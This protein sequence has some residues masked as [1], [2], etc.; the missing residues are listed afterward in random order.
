MSAVNRPRRD[1]L[2][3]GGAL[4]VSFAAPG[5]VTTEGAREAA[6]PVAGSA[7]P[8]TI[9]PHQLDSWLRIA[10]DGSVTASVGK[11]EA[12]MGIGTAF[13]QVVAEELDVPIE[14]VTLV[15]GDTAT[16][17]DQ[18]GTGSSNGIIDGASALKRAAAE[19]R[20]ALLS[21]ASQHLG[22][23]ASA[24]RVRDGVV[25]VASDESKRVT[26]GELIGGRSFNVKVSD[27]PATKDPAQYTVVGKPVPRLDIPPKVQG[28]YRYVGDLQVPGMLHARVIRPP[29]ALAQ[30]VSVDEGAKLPGLVR[31]VR[32]GNYVAVVCEREEQAIDAARK[33]R[34]EWS[35]P[36]PAF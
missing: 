30:V 28:T 4:V 24:L 2:K 19:G 23:P 12:G 18:R 16:T 32:R 15:M 20:A 3:A 29:E 10:A 13:T 7:W 11:I 9:D 8:A 26:Y 34:V 22:V 1:F 21:L 6:L 27:K 5:C 14:R 36:A 25:Y 31:I 33:L 17:V 35:R